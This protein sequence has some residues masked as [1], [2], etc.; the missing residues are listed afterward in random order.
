MPWRKLLKRIDRQASGGCQCGAVRYRTMALRDDA[1]ICHCRMC[2]KAV[3]GPFAALVGA[4]LDGFA[5]TRG[6]PAEFMSSALAARGFCAECGTPLYYRGTRSAHLSLTIASLDDP[7]IAPPVRQCGME[8]RW[9]CLASLDTMPDTGAT[10]EDMAQEAPLIRAS[11]HQHPDH[12]TSAWP[13][14]QDKI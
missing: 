7:S 8:G 4:P 3:G 10:E 6:Q 1:H 14:A 5:W 2:Q 12:D 11:N 13:P 9:P